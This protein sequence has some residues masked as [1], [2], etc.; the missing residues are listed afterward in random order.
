M[1]TMDR[2]EVEGSKGLM[3]LINAIPYAIPIG[4]I[5]EIIYYIEATPLPEAPSFI[6]GVIDLRGKVVPVIDL[7]RKIGMKSQAKSLPDHILILKLRNTLVGL[8]TDA[9]G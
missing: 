7:K 9:T 2:A 5:R 8:D 1:K 3:F 4:S 6:E